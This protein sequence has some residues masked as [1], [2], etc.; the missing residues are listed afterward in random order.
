MLVPVL[1]LLRTQKIR[2]QATD[3]RN[4][5]GLTK[6]MVLVPFDFFLFRERF[7]LIRN[8]EKL[9]KNK[10]VFSVGTTLKGLVHPEI[11]LKNRGEF[12][13]MPE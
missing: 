10:S 7:I 4:L 6:C 2:R 9:N 3:N 11:C 1:F 12:V 13:N 5:S 8:G